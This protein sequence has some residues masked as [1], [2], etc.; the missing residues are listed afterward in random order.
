MYESLTHARAHR[1]SMC[2]T[3][4]ILST[5]VS[6]DGIRFDVVTCETCDG[7]DPEH[8]ENT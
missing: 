7:V 2:L 8:E 5:W 4:T 3:I 6:D 1:C